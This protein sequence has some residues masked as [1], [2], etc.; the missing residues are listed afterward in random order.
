[1][2]KKILYVVTEDWFFCSHFLDRAIAARGAGYEVIVAARE[3]AHAEAIHQAGLTFIPVNFNRRGTNLFHEAATFLQ[4]WKV[5]RQQQPDIV[6]HVALKPI[7]YGSLAA[8][9]ERK[10]FIVNAPVGMGFVFT[11][12]RLLARV[13]KPMVMFAMRHLLNPRRSKVIFENKDDLGAAIQQ[14][15]VRAEC[16]ELIRG[17]GVDTDVIEVR[18]EPPGPVRIVLA[19]RMLWDKGVGEF[20]E[21]ARMVKRT[22][23]DA[24]FQ[25]VGAPDEGNPASVSD[26]Q[27]LTWQKE[28]A[29]EWL[30]QRSDVPAILAD[31]HIACLPSYREGLPKFLLEA[32][33]AGRAVVATDVP[34]CREAVEPGVNGLR[35]PARECAPLAE[36]LMQ[37]I[38]DNETRQRFGK[39]GRLRAEAEFSAK[40]IIGETLALY[41]RVIA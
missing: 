41:R 32:L 2:G 12:R 13:L 36:G 11:S 21:A 29:I 28:G 19:A 1:M 27:L 37:L 16:A 17:A 26:A 30:G 3:G 20:V 4:L 10:P 14:K 18:P 23:P 39:N 6:H 33:A 25:L 38:V 7:L 22:F 9:L 35:V 24:R 8:L 31:S 34:G 5:Y 15:I 40:R